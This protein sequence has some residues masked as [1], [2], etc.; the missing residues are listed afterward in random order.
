MTNT[1]VNY[2]L[3]NTENYKK[4]LNENASDAGQTY[5]DLLLEYIKFIVENIQL[6]NKKLTYFIISRGLDT[7]TNVFLN[8]LLYTKNLKLTYFHCQ[9]SFYF[10]VEFIWQIS[11]DEKTFLQLSSRD[12]TTYVY[13][14]TLFDINYEIKKKN[15]EINNETREKFETI[16]VFVN[17]YKCYILKIIENGNFKDSKLIKIFEE[18]TRKLNSHSIKIDKLK[19]LENVV[20]NINNLTDA[21]AFFEINQ[22]LIKKFIKNNEIIDNCKKK[23]LLEDFVN[24][25]K[26]QP[27]KF[28][29]WLLN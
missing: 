5:C 20:N 12:A 10:Y 16:N 18:L 23:I 21:N 8:L 9:K 14:K 6:K 11:E 3:Y 19:I 15:E 25:I 26:D 7:I 29:T 22:H 27:D 28:I 1:D 24:K 17:L 13:K 2:S 4:E